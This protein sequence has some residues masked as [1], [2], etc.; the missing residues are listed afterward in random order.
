MQ[1]NNALPGFSFHLN[2]T[3][4]RW[5]GMLEASIFRRNYL[6]PKHSADDI[7]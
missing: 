5:L 2:G 1:L 3:L 6:Q 4:N 7:A